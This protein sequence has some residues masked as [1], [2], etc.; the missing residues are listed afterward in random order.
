MILVVG[1]TGTTGGATLRALLARGARVRALTHSPDKVDELEALGAEVVVGDLGEPASLAPAFAG[2]ERAFVAVHGDADLVE[3]ESNA[4]AAAEAAGVR[5]VVKISVVG[6]AH[7]SPLRFA[8]GHAELFD[9][10]QASSLGWTLLLCS[11]YMQNFLLAPPGITARPDALVAHVDAR[12]VG[13]V[14]ARV[15]TEDGHERCTYTLTGPEAL[16]DVQVTQTIGEVL[17]LE[18]PVV[19]IPDEVLGRALRDGGMT[20]WEA[21]GVLELHALQRSGAFAQPAPDAEALLGRP[22]TAFRQ[23]AA[24]HRPV[25]AAFAAAAG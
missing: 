22:P 15:L 1:A 25:F 3:L 12:D 2:V 16:T 5:A 8:R 6:Q 10:L 13:A 9:T 14:A 24:D 20:A 4:Y 23:F 17:G 21:D 19:P 18:L 11:G 7:D